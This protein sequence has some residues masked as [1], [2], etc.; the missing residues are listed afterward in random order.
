MRVCLAVIALIAVLLVPT[1]AVA[2]EVEGVRLWDSPERTRVVFD[3]SDPAD[4]RLFTLSDPE[5]IVI[6]LSDAALSDGFS[7]AGEGVVEGIRSGVRDETD[8]RLVLDL[9][10]DARPRSFMVPP[11]EQYGHRLV[12]DLERRGNT[13]RAREAVREMPSGNDRPVVVAIDAGHGGED[14]GAIGPNGTREKDVVMQIAERI[15]A[16][17]EAEPGMDPFMIRTGDYFVALRDRVRRAREAR[18]DVFI[19]IHADAFH[20]PRARGASVFTLSEQGASHQAAEWLANRENAADLIGG[21]KLSDKED[22]VASVLMDLSQSA[23]ISASLDLGDRLLEQMSPS[24]RMHKREVMQAGF[25]VLKAPDIPSILMESAFISNPQEERLL[26]QREYQERIAGSVVDGVRDYFWANPVP[27]T[28]IARMVEE[29][30][31]PGQE[32]RIARGETLSA[33]AR[34]Y[35]VSI[36][37]LR[38]A[39]NLSGDR[40]R[41]GQVLTIPTS[42]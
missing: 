6:D 14:P 1:T 5:R 31:R 21:V 9:Q 29:G 2:T 16:R 17:V 18:A 40:I 42:G 36:D 41:T 20:D 39:N 19:S 11:N 37:R 25:A 38:Q 30:E 15:R 26:K 35:D 24:M 33:I 34:K 13:S 7:P 8:L 28:R 32:H 10:E 3:L 23:S 4:H 27:G 12:V 22:T